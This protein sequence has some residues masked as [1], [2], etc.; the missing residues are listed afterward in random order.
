MTPLPSA[1]LVFKLIGEELIPCSDQAVRFELA[2]EGAGMVSEHVFQEAAAAVLLYFRNELGR[3]AISVSEFS[4][5]LEV[6]L[7]SLGL[8]QVKAAAG[9]AHLEEAVKETDLQ[10]LAVDGMELL[11]FQRLREELRRQL[12]P[13]PEVLRFRG[14]RPSV[15]RLTGARRWSPSCQALK[16][17]IIDFM[18][19]SLQSE[20]TSRPCGLVIH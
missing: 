9:P 4:A 13:S 11:F 14:L 18:R 19:H 6:V 7:H 17:R 3:T 2:G 20:P 12:L 8:T 1:S 10:I 5:A 16:E 15:M